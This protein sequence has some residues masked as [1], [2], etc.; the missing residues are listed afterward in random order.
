M[1]AS[2]DGGSQF[3]RDLVKVRDDF[4]SLVKFAVHDA[5]VSG[6][7]LIDG[8]AMPRFVPLFLFF[9]SYCSNLE[10]FVLDLSRN[11]RDLGFRRVLSPV[12]FEE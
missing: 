2:S 6:F 5:S 4:R 7:G 9:F 10:I 11:N 1:L 8:M 3:W 12:E